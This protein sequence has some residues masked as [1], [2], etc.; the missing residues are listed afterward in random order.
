MVRFLRIERGW[1][2]ITVDPDVTNE[3][4]VNFWNK[5]GFD[6]ERIIDD[7]QRPPYWLM[8]WPTDE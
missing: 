8:H 1:R 6:P 5:V 7:T 4:G 3:R 2:H